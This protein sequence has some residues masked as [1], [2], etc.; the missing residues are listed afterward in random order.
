MRQK[1]GALRAEALW[2]DGAERARLAEELRGPSQ[3][4]PRRDL[5]WTVIAGQ[6]AHFLGDAFHLL[7]VL[8]LLL[9]PWRFA[10]TLWQCFGELGARRSA[11][12]AARTLQALELW[13]E[14]CEGIAGSAR[15][16]ASGAANPPG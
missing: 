14:E 12:M 6:F 16:A 13:C 4:T 9:V 5:V 10:L 11:R 8:A 15:G 7:L 2:A 3:R 1:D